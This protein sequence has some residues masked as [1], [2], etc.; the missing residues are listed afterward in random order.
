MLNIGLS[1]GLLLLVLGLLFLKP[2]QFSETARWLGR[3]LREARKMGKSFGQ[4][5]LQESDFKDLGDVAKTARKALSEGKK[6]LRDAV[7]L[8]DTIDVT[9][10]EPAAA[11]KKSDAAKRAAVSEAEDGSVTSTNSGGDDSSEAI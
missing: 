6:A 3:N 9:P 8:D 2:D 10:N 5:L 4:A 7:S 11:T 1:E